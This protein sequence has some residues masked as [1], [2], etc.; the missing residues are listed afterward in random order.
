MLAHQPLPFTR[1]SN[2]RQAW[3]NA[4]WTVLGWPLT[5]VISSG[6]RLTRV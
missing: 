4:T 1:L 6:A 3:M 2:L 5:V